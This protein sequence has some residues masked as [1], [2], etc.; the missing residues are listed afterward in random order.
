MFRS[1]IGPG[2]EMYA[3]HGGGFPVY[4]QADPNLLVGTIIVSGL[5]QESDH[6]VI[7]ES[8]IELFHKEEREEILKLGA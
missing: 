6:M 3:V 2:A 5:V 4:L 7:V 1:K 8:L